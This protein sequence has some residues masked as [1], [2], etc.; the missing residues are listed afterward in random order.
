MS[1]RITI[2]GNRFPLLSISRA[3]SE[4]EP[5]TLVDISCRSMLSL[6]TMPLWS[7]VDEQVWHETFFPLLIT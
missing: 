5:V 6:T 7:P 2:P 3:G 4:R 1:S